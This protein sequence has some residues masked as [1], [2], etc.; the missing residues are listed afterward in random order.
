MR[1]CCLFP[2]T[3]GCVTLTSCR[4]VSPT[5]KSQ[6]PDCS[7]SR[8]PLLLCSPG[9]TLGALLQVLCAPTAEAGTDPRRFQRPERDVSCSW[10]HWS[11]AGAGPGPSMATEMPVGEEPKP[12]VGPFPA[13]PQLH[14]PRAS[15][16][17]RQERAAPGYDQDGLHQPKRPAPSHRPPR[18]SSSGQIMDFAFGLNLL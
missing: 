11:R 5:L 16:Q 6:E 13:W 1:S 7:D 12:L 17:P 2:I 9:A 10:R 8:A 14:A 18:W 4:I 15:L 3:H